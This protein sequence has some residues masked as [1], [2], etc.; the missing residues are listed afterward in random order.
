MSAK[1]KLI[2]IA[3]PLL[4]I[5]V[6]ILAAR[7][8]IATRPEPR[9]V[10]RETPGALVATVTVS[11]CE[12]QVLVH[13]TGTVQARQQVEIV[14]QVS[15]QV[16]E[17]SPSL[18]VGGFFRQ[19]DLLF[20]VEQADY[21]LAVDRARAA[22]AKAEFDLATVEGQARVARQEW[23]RLDFAEG[24]EQPNPLVLYEPQLKNAQAALLS[25]RAA[26]RQAE[27][28]LQ[29]TAVHAPFAGVVRSE[30]VDLGQYVRSG[31][32]A[33]VLIGTDQAEII[34]PL[35]LHEL[36][37]LQIPRPGEKA[38]GSPATVQ[39]TTGGRSFEWSGRIV[40]SLGEVDPQGRM[41]RVVVAIEDPYGLQS[42]APGRPELAVGTFVQVEL[43]GATLPDVA[44]LPAAALRDGGQVWVMNDRQLKFRQVE[45]IR[46]A[47]EDVMIGAGLQDGEQ[48]VLTNVAGAA[49]G[50]QLRPLDEARPPLPAAE[51]EKRDE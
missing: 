46:R 38:P 6:G 29:R 34:V 10:V 20:R 12:R 28:D 16:V 1:S 36:G 15:G 45:V 2:K 47:R 42:R 32:P 31:S 43:H 13:G 48:V 27:L 9:K 41:A 22:L 35:P 23:G 33:A 11:R 18:V 51:A 37:W 39:L 19:G 3:L 24:K 40:R 44:I 50:M 5:A 8:L 49:E 26:Q 21:R 7:I 14:P 25:A 4:I 17:I 30:A